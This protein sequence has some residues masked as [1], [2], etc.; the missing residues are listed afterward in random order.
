[1]LDVYEASVHRL[2][3]LCLVLD[4]EH[5]PYLRPCSFMLSLP[6]SMQIPRLSPSAHADLSTCRWLYRTCSKMSLKLSREFLLHDSSTK[7]CATFSLSPERSMGHSLGY[8]S[9]GTHQ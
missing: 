7:W 2:L 1:M 5:N 4:Q 3:W 9:V 8:E 6:A